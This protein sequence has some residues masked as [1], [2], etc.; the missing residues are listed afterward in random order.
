[1]AAQRR[2]EL[3]ESGLR[4]ERQLFGSV[5]ARV[6]AGQVSPLERGRVQVSLSGGQVARDKAIRDLRVARSRLS[7]Q[8]ASTHPVFGSALGD[9][10]NVMAVHP[11]PDLLRMASNN[12]DLARWTTEIAQREARVAVERAKN[13]PDPRLTLGARRYGYNTGETSFVAGISIPLPIYSLNR[14]GIQEAEL[15]ASKGRALQQAAAVQVAAAIEQSFEQLSSAYDTVM[16]LRRALPGAKS[17]VDGV[18]LGYREGKFTLLEALDAQRAYLDARGRLIDAEATYQ[19]VRA[20]AERLTGQSL[21]SAP[22]RGRG[23]PL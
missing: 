14:G 22:S 6:D 15:L 19:T 2:V 16:T 18:G 23:A 11:L 3:A 20:D 7:A 12:P 17:T 4:L 1:L 5:G 13:T 10:E 8:W 21:T 9:L